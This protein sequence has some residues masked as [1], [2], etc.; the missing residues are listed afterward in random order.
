MCRHLPILAIVLALIVSA[1]MEQP[2]DTSGASAMDTLAVQTRADSVAMN[3]YQEFGGPDAWSSLRL[4]RFDFAGGTDSTRNLRARHLWNRESGDYRVEM[5]QGEDSV[6]VALFNVNTRSGSVYLNGEP[7]DTTRET[8]LLQNAYRRFVNDSYW[9]LM[10]VKMFDPGVTRA[11]V[12]DSSDADT[13]VLRLSFSD[14]GL[15][16]GD[17]YWIYVDRETGRI[18]KWAYQ[19]QHHGPDHVPQPIEWSGYKTM[20]APGG[21]VLVSERKVGPGFVL[22]TDNVAVPTEVE[23]GAFTDPNPMLSDS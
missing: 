3:V 14:V 1:C 22:Y 6:Y 9:L 19:L 13:D 5:P 23:D 10:P 2:A 18:E 16:P 21:E 15:T 4:L 8:E 12:A 17:Q 20:E 7:V 11:Y